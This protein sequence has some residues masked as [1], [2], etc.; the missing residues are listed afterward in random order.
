MSSSELVGRLACLYLYIDKDSRFGGTIGGDGG[1]KSFGVGRV[2]REQKHY[3]RSSDW[4]AEE[5]AKTKHVI[6][7]DDH[8]ATP[9]V[10]D[11]RNPLAEIF[12]HSK[13]LTALFQHF[14]L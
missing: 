14:S 7:A 4:E 5:L 11:S 3:S 13:S 12:S 9:D 6:G 8:H 10:R 2:K 1:G